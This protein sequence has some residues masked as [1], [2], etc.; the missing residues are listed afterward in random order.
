M[1]LSVTAKYPQGGSIKGGARHG[2]NGGFGMGTEATGTPT[3]FP[4][5]YKGL[6]T[7][8]KDMYCDIGISH[9]TITLGNGGESSIFDAARDD[10]RRV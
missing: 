10:R 9:K 4:Q 8:V 2:I 1:N 7:I 3:A 5:G 6:S